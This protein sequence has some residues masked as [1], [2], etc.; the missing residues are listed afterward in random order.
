M[1]TTYFIPIGYNGLD[2]IQ[3]M[4]FPWLLTTD[5]IK[6][7]IA[8][9]E[10]VMY[11]FLFLNLSIAFVSIIITWHVSMEILKS[12]GLLKGIKWKQHNLNAHLFTIVVWIASLIVSTYI[13]EP[14]FLE[15]SSYLINFLPPFFV[16]FL[17]ICWF[18]SWRD[19]HEDEDILKTN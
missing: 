9:L 18:I 3:Y 7:A 15:Y 2:H 12:S 4:S 17:I 11:I 10:R 14:Q 1:F 19:K 8:F 5:S 13:T 16:V 6:V